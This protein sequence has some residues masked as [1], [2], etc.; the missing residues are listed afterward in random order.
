[1]KNVLVAS[2]PGCFVAPARML[3][4]YARNDDE[5]K[6]TFRQT[7]IAM[8]LLLLLTAATWLQASANGYGQT[9]SLHLKNVSLEKVFAEIQKQSNY[10]FIY[11]KEEMKETKAITIE[12]NKVTIAEALD[13]CLK[14]QPL[15]YTIKE[16]YIII[17]RKEESKPVTAAINK[18]ILLKGKII[19][20]R[21]EGIAGATVSIKGTP[22]AIATNE[23][24]EYQIEFSTSG[25]VALISCI[26]YETQEVNI[27]GRNYIEV[28]LQTAINSL[29][30]TIVIAYGNT[31]RRLNT[32]NVSKVTAGEISKQPVSNPLAALQGRVPGL[33]I[34]QSSGL[35]GAGFKVQIRGQN[36]LI[37]GSEPFYIIDGVPFAPGNNPVNQLSNATSAAGLSPFNLINP[38]D[39]ESIEVLK[40]ADATAIYGSRGANGVILITTKKGKQGKT[41]LSANVYSGQSRVTRTMDML[42][43]AQ[44]VAMRKEAFANDGIAMTSTNAPDI[45]VW[46]TTRYTD[47]KKLFTGGS[48]HSLDAQV[49][50]S[51]GSENTHFL[52]SG[53]YHRETTVLPTDLAD[54][55]VSVHFN[56]NHSSNDKKFLLNLSGNYS[57][58]NN[59]LTVAD[60]TASINLPPNIQLTDADGKLKWVDGGIPYWSITGGNP[61]SELRKIFSGKYEN[62]LGNLKMSYQI[63]PALTIRGSIGYNALTGDE[64]SVNPSTSLD[65][66]LSN[67]PFANFSNS[68]K[69]SWIAEPQAEYVKDWGKGKLS[70]LAGG[71]WQENETNSVNVFGSN[72]SSDLFLYSIA[73]AGNVQAVNARS[74]YK[75]VA[76]FGRINYNY[77]NTYILNFSGRRDGSSRF[78]DKRQFSNFAAAGAAWVF[79][80][81]RFFAKKAS[82]LS[83][84]K[85]R[86]S[87]GVT[88]NDQIGDYKYLDTWTASS[89]TYQ[90]MSSL[91]PTSLFNP[92]YEW[93]KNIKLEIGLETGFFNDRILFSA[94]YFRNR[95]SNQIINYTLPVQTG[96]NSIGRNLDAVIRNTGTEFVL[97]SRNITGKKF[98]WTSAFNL[99]VHRNKLLSFPGLATSSYATQFV[100]GESVTTRRVYYSPGVDPA[101]GYYVFQDIDNNGI[102]NAADRIEFA[103]TDPKLWGGLSNS[104]NWRGIELTIFL[105]FKKQTGRNY[106]ITQGG[107][108]PGYTIS[109]QPVSVLDRWR[110]PGDAATVQRFTVNDNA[111]AFINSTRNLGG[112][113]VA[114]TDA[115]FIRCKNA[116]LSYQLPLP[117]VK[118]LHIESCKVFA[119]A[120]NVFTITRYKGADPENQNLYVLPPLRTITTGIQVNF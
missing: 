103:R 96:F 119:Q 7:L 57:A 71:T 53:G 56:V 40:D 105:E 62:L 52:A 31:T 5:K 99:T 36:S 11:T 95:C 55:R 100:T 45:L 47:F 72:Y 81:E 80:N 108:F 49:S 97:T 16:P 70:V 46:D 48:A 93:E 91:N 77:S 86:A 3:L 94:S 67:L 76:I 22:I 98:N 44:Y 89:T 26:G 42:N 23:K 33:I 35:N 29:D 115:S 88:G 58:D 90:G 9:I 102:Y 25:T 30:E 32:G 92:N 109:N 112:S 39:I 73:G 17:K 18:P 4:R 10:Q 83:F 6:R 34:T 13:I 78:G 12:V 106:L 84:G 66:T 69:K 104:F 60:L 75:Y 50:L 24:G 111:A 20:E 107:F 38:S 43:T 101:T 116:A 74:Q 54:K 82:F 1:M 59:R 51:G 8:R 110:K 37:Q 120:Q 117:I 2:P 68:T 113:N 65:P 27:N 19:N 79:S 114:Y 63:I 28:I 41:M 61:L 21:G 87:Y 118:K 15:T 64:T 85:L 14:E